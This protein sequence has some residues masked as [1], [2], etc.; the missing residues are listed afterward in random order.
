MCLSRECGFFFSIQESPRSENNSIIICQAGTWSETECYMATSAKCYYYQTRCWVC[1]FPKGYMEWGYSLIPVC[2]DIYIY[3]YIHVYVCS[4]GW[5][6]YWSWIDGKS[7]GGWL[8]TVLPE[9]RDV[10]R[11][12]QRHVARYQWREE[13]WYSQRCFPRLFR[14]GNWQKGVGHRRRQATQVGISDI[15]YRIPVCP[16]TGSHRL[17]R[18]ARLC[19]RALS[20]A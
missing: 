18:A 17:A 11:A 6:E 10:S 7:T 13:G 9:H 2:G 4:W 14:K 8:H 19:A 16:R 12:F 5:L 1:A 15:T 3:I 20:S